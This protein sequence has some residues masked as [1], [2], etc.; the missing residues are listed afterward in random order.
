LGRGG[1]IAVQ[2]Q[3]VFRTLG[4]DD[5]KG[6]I[7]AGLG[8]RSSLRDAEEFRLPARAL[9]ELNCHDIYLSDKTQSLS[10]LDSYRVMLSGEAGAYDWLVNDNEKRRTYKVF[11][12]GG[13]GSSVGVQMDSPLEEVQHIRQELQQSLLRPYLAYGT[14]RGLDSDG[15]Y[16]GVVLVHA[17]EELARENAALLQ[18]RIEGTVNLARSTPWRETVDIE[19][20]EIRTEGRLLVAR[21]PLQEDAGYTL[22][23][24]LLHQ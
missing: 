7:D 3:Y 4:T 17:E 14:G 6:L 18:Q 20:M 9:S 2:D 22:D 23:G 11:F 12:W 1:R 16:I 24:L 8:R 5:M 19:R 15:T 10:E 21:L 13:D